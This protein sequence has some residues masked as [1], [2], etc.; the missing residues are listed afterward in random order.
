MNSKKN[1]VL[2]Y[3]AITKDRLI[4]CIAAD[5]MLRIS[6]IDGTN[7]A[8]EAQRVH[9][10]SRVATAAMGRQLM[11]TAI[12]AADLK[13]EGDLISTILKGDGPAGSLICTGNSRLEVKGSVTNA[14]VEL[15][16]TPEGK[17]NVGGYIGHTGKLSVVSDLGLKEPYVGL[18]NLISGEIAVDFA[19][20][21]AASLQRP[22]LVYLGV[23]EDAV[24]GTVR[25]AAGI[26]AEPLPGCSDE[27]I[28]Q[29]QAL[30]GEI[31]TFSERLDA[32]EQ[33][34]E[35]LQRVFGA[36]GAQIVGER[37][38]RYVCDC[39]RVRVER[40]L[41]SIGKEEV[42]DMIAQDHGAEV[43]CQFCDKV[44]TFNED[45]LTELLKNATKREDEEE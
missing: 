43:C 22:A 13:G 24:T 32:G 1:N 28:D 41:I 8:R 21:F 14:E 9:H 20:Y 10:S 2:P 30:E 6:L 5:G 40:A 29:L 19:N 44:Y 42:Q 16:L 34:D 4:Q 23:R 37:E 17:L 3:K 27:A 18:C 38:P 45:E 7:L 36:L 11:M 12:M 39:S 25:A 35:F 31:A 33:P 15:P 26:L